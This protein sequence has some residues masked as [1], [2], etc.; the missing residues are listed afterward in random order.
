[1][2]SYVKTIVATILVYLMI[3]SMLPVSVLSV[4][5]LENTLA[6][7]GT[8]D[9]P[10]LITSA[11]EFA[12]AMNTYGNSDDVHFSLESDILVSNNIVPEVFKGEPHP[13]KRTEK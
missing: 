9:S 10:F 8:A 6:G 4:G 3:L 5:A 7:D 2:K 13:V 12:Y 11:D 1:M